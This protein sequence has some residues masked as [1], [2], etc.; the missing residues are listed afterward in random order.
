MKKCYNCGN[1][2]DDA[3]RF[4]EKCGANVMNNHENNINIKKENNEKVL[5]GSKGLYICSTLLGVLIVAMLVVAVITNMKGNSSKDYLNDDYKQLNENIEN[6]GIVFSG[7]NEKK[8]NELTQMIKNID[9]YDEEK[10]KNSIT[11]LNDA[12]SSLKQY[13]AKIKEYS[14]KIKE[15]NSVAKENKITKQCGSYKSA[16]EKALKRLKQTIKDNDMDKLEEN[17]KKVVNECK[18]YNDVKENYIIWRKN[19]E[20]IEQINETA[21]GKDISEY[22][23]IIKKKKSAISALENF[24][25]AINDDS[26]KDIDENKNKL[27]S[28]VKKYKS[29]VNSTKA[30]KTVIYKYKY[31][32][33]ISDNYGSYGNEFV[34]YDSRNYVMDVDEVERWLINNGA[35]NREIACWFTLAINEIS[36]RYGAGFSTNSLILYFSGKT[37]YQNWGDDP[38]AIR[39][40]FT[41]VEKRN[42]D[43]FGRKRNEYCRRIGISTSA[44]EYSYDEFNYIANNYSY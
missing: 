14:D 21:S 13:N 26:A 3:D 36:A 43:N 44:K 11:S 37:W 34:A 30:K 32:P 38:N 6:A 2:L 41:S 25:N 23:N 24:E 12:V 1:I 9:S 18:K 10:I 17:L 15:Y 22:Q 19:K 39:K 31:L 16:C 40:V 8:Y 5:K 33:S 4:C 27:L 7:D 29:V 42:F 20:N 35:T 28:S